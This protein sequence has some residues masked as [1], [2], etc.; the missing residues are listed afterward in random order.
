MA[1]TDVKKLSELAST[2][3]ASYAYFD[4]INEPELIKRLILP[5]ADHGVGMTVSQRDTFVNR[6]DLINQHANDLTGFYATLFTDALD[7]NKKVLALRGTEFTQSFGQKITDGAIADVL[8]IAGAGFANFQAVQLYR[9]VKELT[10]EGRQSVQ[11]SDDD[12]A[13]IAMVFFA[14]QIELAT[15]ILPQGTAHDIAVWASQQTAFS[16]LIT[17]LAN[18][19]GIGTGAALLQAG[20]K[21]DVTGHS[22]GGHLALL[23]ARMFPQ[24][25]DQVVTLNA[26]T[27]F[28]NGDAFLTSIGFPPGSGANI[29][30][31]EADGDAVHL[32][33]NVDPGYAIAIAQETFPD[34]ADKVI[35]NHSSVNGV[36]SLNLTALIAKLDPTLINSPMQISDFI[37]KASNDYKNTYEKTLDALRHM[38]LGGSVADTIISTDSSDT[39]RSS[40]YD[41]MDA[42]QNSAIFQSLIGHVTLTATPTSS[43]EARTDFSAFLSLFYLTPF[44]LK[45]NNAEANNLLLAT[46]QALGDKWTDDYNL[47]SEDLQNGKAN[48]SDM[49]LADRAAML[50]WV[51]FAN[52]DDIQTSAG[53]HALNNGIPNALVDATQR[54]YFK[55]ITSQTEIYLSGSQDRRKFIFGSNADDAGDAAINGG[56]LSDHLY[57]MGGNDTINGGDGNDYIE[58]N[59]GQNTLKGEAGNDVLLGGTDVD[60]LDGGDGNDQLKGGDGVDVYQF[61]GDYGTD[62]ITDSDGQGMIL[63]GG[64][65]NSGGTPLTSGTFKLEN[66][67]KDDRTG[68]IITKVDGGTKVIISK[69]NDPNRIII[70][71][72]SE[73]KNLGLDL[74]GSMPAAPQATLSGDFKK[75]IN[76]NGTPSDK[77]DDYYE[78]DSNGNY[79]K[80]TSQ[81]DGNEPSALDLITGTAGND[82]IKG[83]GGSDAL[84]GKGGDD[85]IDGGTEGDVLQ[86]GMGAD[87]LMGGTGSDL[88]YGSSN[89]TTIKPTDAEHTPPTNPYANAQGSGFNWTSGYN[90]G[91]V[92]SNGTPSGYLSN[93][94]DRDRQAGDAGNLIDGGAGDDLI[95]AG[96]GADYVH[97]VASND[98]DWRMTA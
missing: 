53:Q 50:S 2:A 18:D 69:E 96:T 92:F 89:G 40:L 54:Y 4:F 20:D 59:A 49:W 6:Y 30:R 80:D 65:A 44:T 29:T 33:G 56:D 84:S 35:G 23:F 24:Y 9:Y 43:S 46:H 13:K 61:K 82:V 38:I 74:T 7:G 42:L 93:I 98:N 26:P 3:L 28:A 63:M 22:L 85:Y 34:L 71:G 58:G 11:Y 94:I 15:V 19:R 55:D 1:I 25:T 8:G 76:D 36:D 39:N 97:R 60:I 48:F 51:N 86:G 81:G 62:I 72:W 14:K 83:L 70:N 68:Y 17:D 64:D 12:I 57:G 67:Y 77:T 91:D 90:G 41:S 95:A 21:I 52:K 87:T 31:L 47:N 27:F 73:A 16:S 37:R 75:L 66:I 78:L 32:I 79:K 10:T 88:I 45:T 5:D